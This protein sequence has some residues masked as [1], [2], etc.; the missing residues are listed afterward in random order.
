[1][2]AIL[3]V[4]TKFSL[5]KNALFVAFLVDEVNCE[6]AFPF[7]EGGSRRLTDEVERDL[8]HFFKIY[9]NQQG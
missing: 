7:G 9:V 3:L 4:Q 5:C 1:M 6:K 8:S 2:Y